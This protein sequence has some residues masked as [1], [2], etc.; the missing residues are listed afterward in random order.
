L[1]K[2]RSVGSKIFRERRAYRL[3][4][5]GPGKF[6]HKALPEKKWNPTEG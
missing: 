3:G 4:G 6:E 1:G 2:V 5:F